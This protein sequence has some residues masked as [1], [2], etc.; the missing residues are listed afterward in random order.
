[1]LNRIIEK[2]EKRVLN[3]YVQDSFF[4]LD[5]HNDWQNHWAAFC[6]FI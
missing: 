6:L 1:M 2:Y 3:C 5:L 4:V